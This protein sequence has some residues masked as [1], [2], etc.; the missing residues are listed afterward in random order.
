MLVARNVQASE[1]HS[2]L[3]NFHLR[4]QQEAIATD[5]PRRLYHTHLQS[6]PLYGNSTDLQY[7]YVDVYVGSQKHRQA[8]IVDTGSGI[9]AL[10]CEKYCQSCGK[11]ING[12]YSLEQSTTEE[13][14]NCKRDQC[15]CA[16]DGPEEAC[17]FQ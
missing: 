14:Y 9:A 1:N 8:L 7:F 17:S 10:P 3:N 4:L 6:A 16:N 2:L 11:H 12:Y 13:V 5:V 15:S